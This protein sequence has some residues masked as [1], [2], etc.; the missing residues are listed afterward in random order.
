M[1][2]H[3]SPA[4]PHRDPTSEEELRNLL[5]IADRDRRQAA[6]PGLDPDG[7]FAFAYNA[8]LQLATAYLRL[9]QVRVSAQSRHFQTFQELRNLL[10]PEH[11]R[12]AVEFERARRKR[13]ALMYDQAG[14]ASEG[15]AADLLATVDDFRGIVWNAIRERFPGFPTPL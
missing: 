3:G 12:F 11:R 6:L 5:R 1:P 14:L 8:A 4:S 9:H 2:W 10:P 13:H 7:K 15:E